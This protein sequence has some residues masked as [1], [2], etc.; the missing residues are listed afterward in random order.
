MKLAYKTVNGHV[1]VRPIQIAYQLDGCASTTPPKIA[2]SRLNPNNF[3]NVKANYGFNL[4]ST[5]VLR[6]DFF[7]QRPH[8]EVLRYRRPTVDHLDEKL[9]SVMI[10]RV[11][12][13][14][15]E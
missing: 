15:T 6:L 3:Q 4:F 7:E 12:S 14:T 2:F 13:A 10:S 1:Y 9:I 8:Y 11:P 5:K